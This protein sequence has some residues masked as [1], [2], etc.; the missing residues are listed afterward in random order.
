MFVMPMGEG[1]C[2]GENSVAEVVR[3]DSGHHNSQTGRTKTA[4]RNTFRGQVTQ[5]HN[6]D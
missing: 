1:S 5:R 6:N 2:T 4:S 3:R